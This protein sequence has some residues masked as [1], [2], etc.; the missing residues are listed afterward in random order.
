MNLDLLLTHAR[1]TWHQL[2]RLPRRGAEAARDRVIRQLG[3]TLRELSFAEVEL[4][5]LVVAA[6][7]S[8]DVDW[9]GDSLE[10][11]PANDARADALAHARDALSN[12]GAA[13]S[14]SDERRQAMGV[15]AE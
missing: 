5:Q 1:T 3:V 2:D 9:D 4:L 8:D 6:R 12:L 15:A 11:Q 7:L 13:I 10:G 14:L